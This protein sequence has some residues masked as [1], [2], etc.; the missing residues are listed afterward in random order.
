GIAVITATSISPQT[1][2]AA[3][4]AGYMA[5]EQIAGKPCKAS[6][7]YAL[8]IVVYEWLCGKQPFEGLFFEICAQ[9]LHVPIPS[10]RAKRP[11]I[12]L[13]VE[14]CLLKALAKDPQERFA[15]VQDFALALQAACERARDAVTGV[16]LQQLVQEKP[17][18]ITTSHDNGIILNA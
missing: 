5:P 1:K 3:G 17:A 9:H 13:E 14:H 6:D 18:D 16:S 10:V 11:E 7:Q 8:G 12:P 4:T 2:T 15:C